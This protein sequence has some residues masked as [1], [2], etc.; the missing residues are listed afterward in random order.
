MQILF[1]FLHHGQV[2]PCAGQGQKIILCLKVCPEWKLY[3]YGLH[4]PQEE[5]PWDISSSLELLEV[6]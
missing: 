4:I 6:E 3:H 1:K 2:R 5:Y